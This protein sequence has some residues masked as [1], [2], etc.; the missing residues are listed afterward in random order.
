ME[1]TEFVCNPASDH[2]PI[3]TTFVVISGSTDWAPSSNALTA[4]ITIGIAYG[5][6]NPSFLLCVTLAAAIPHKYI[7]SQKFPPTEDIFPSAIIPP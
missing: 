5:A 7:D 3:K 1:F 6:T 2:E 4:A